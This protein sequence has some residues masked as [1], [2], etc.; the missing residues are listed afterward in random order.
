VREYD[1]I[2]FNYIFVHVKINVDDVEHNCYTS[3]KPSVVFFSLLLYVS[4]SSLCYVGYDR[5]ISSVNTG[6]VLPQWLIDDND[7]DDDDDDRLCDVGTTLF[8]VVN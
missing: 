1:S 2:C 3:S 6:C 5:F 8:K 4:V 7:D